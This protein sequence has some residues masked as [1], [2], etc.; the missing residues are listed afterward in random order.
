[1]NPYQRLFHCFSKP[2][3]EYLPNQVL[4][5][6]KCEY[7]LVEIMF[8]NDYF[9]VYYRP[10]KKRYG[11]LIARYGELRQAVNRLDTFN[12]ITD[13]ERLFGDT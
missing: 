4:A 8:W 2:T 10:L 1:M 9:E 13:L 5:V 12:P 11:Y 3:H 7:G 6:R